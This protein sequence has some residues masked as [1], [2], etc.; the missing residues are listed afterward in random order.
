L[1][2]LVKRLLASRYAVK[3]STGEIEDVVMDVERGERHV[4][5]VVGAR[6]SGGFSGANSLVDGRRMDVD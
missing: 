6:E 1:V 3:G 2:A 5:A 4:E